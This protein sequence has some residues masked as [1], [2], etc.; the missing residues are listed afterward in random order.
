MQKISFLINDKFGDITDK[1][2]NETRENW[3][4]FVCGLWYN[5]RLTYMWLGQ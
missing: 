4:D 1:S 2:S 5:V 3:C